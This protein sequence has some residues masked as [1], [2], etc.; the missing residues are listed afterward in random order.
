MHV[1]RVPRH[2]ERRLR[3]ADRLR[4]LGKLRGNKFRNS[5]DASL[6]RK[7]GKLCSVCRILYQE[8]RGAFRKTEGSSKDFDFTK[9]SVRSLFDPPMMSLKVSFRIKLLNINTY[10]LLLNVAN[11][12][13]ISYKFYRPIQ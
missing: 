7:L 3:H 8:L 1:R 6:D 10:N 13:A 4:Q 11:H 9:A 2:R 5:S 12:N